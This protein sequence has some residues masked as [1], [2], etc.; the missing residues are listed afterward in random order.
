MD[1][2]SNNPSI[3]I[4]HQ[5]T[6]SFF[7]EPIQIALFEQHPNSLLVCD[8]NTLFIIDHR[9]GDLIHQIDTRSL[10]IKTIKA[11]TIGLQD[12][13]IIGDHR[14]HVLSY[15]GKYLREFS[16]T[17]Q[18]QIV[19]VDVHIAH[20]PPDLIPVHYKQ[21]QPLNMISQNG[22]SISKGGREKNSLFWNCEDNRMRIYFRR[23]LHCTLCRSK[24]TSFGW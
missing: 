18:Q 2:S 5:I 19:D 6:C 22:K 10:G 16:S 12:E 13:I 24:W 9:T 15:E 4:H 21:S 8:N 3:N 11:F 1:S 14:I 20:Q 7:N 17:I 23:F